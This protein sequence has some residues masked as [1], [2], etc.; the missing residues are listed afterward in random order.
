[1]SNHHAERHQW[2]LTPTALFRSHAPPVFLE[3][4]HWLDGCWPCGRSPH[5]HELLAGETKTPGTRRF[6]FAPG[7]TVAELRDLMAAAHPVHGGS[8]AAFAAARERWRTIGK[9]GR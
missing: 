2:R 3:P 1:M 9:I 7:P 8:Y 4:R 5:Q 6:K